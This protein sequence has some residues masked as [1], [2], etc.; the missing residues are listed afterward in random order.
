M[1]TFEQKNIKKIIKRKVIGL[2]FSNSTFK[3]FV[4]KIAINKENDQ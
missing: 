1:K 2:F 3:V 4:T